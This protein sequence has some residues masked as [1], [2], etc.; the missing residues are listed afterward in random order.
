MIVSL[1]IE[2]LK[3]GRNINHIP[4][5]HKDSTQWL[6]SD[7][8]E[9]NLEDFIIEHIPIV[10][11]YY[12]T[13]ENCEKLIQ[14]ITDYRISENPNK[15]IYFHCWAGKGRT[16][17]VVI[18]IL[19]KLYNLS[20]NDATFL[21]GKNYSGCST[22]DAQYRFLKGGY[23]LEGD[24]VDIQPIIKTPKDHSCYLPLLKEKLFD[25]EDDEDIFS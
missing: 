14:I 20:F 7:L 24:I 1:T 12:P 11:T 5:D 16:C 18:Y 22:K 25:D 13:Q 6:D 10:D 15:K 19:M 17:T 21:V 23:S 4:F 3:V 8:E 9:S 2:K